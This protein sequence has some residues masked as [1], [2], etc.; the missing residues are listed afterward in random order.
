M[1][2]YAQPPALEARMS[3][4]F[5]QAPRFRNAGETHKM[6]PAQVPNQRGS[7][8]AQGEPSF[9]LRGCAAPQASWYSEHL[10]TELLQPQSFS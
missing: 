2:A 7:L 1:H 5:P 8:Q 6:V 10:K 4:L 9:R 3:S